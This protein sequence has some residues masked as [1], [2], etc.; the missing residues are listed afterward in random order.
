MKAGDQAKGYKIFKDL[1]GKGNTRAENEMGVMNEHGEGIP[2][3]SSEAMKWYLKAADKGYPLAQCNIGLMFYKGEGVPR[4][5]VQAYKWFDLA[6]L[7]GN[8]HA[9]GYIDIIVR[10][11]NHGE[12]VEGQRLAR[13]WQSKSA[14]P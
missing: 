6:M 1:A 13:E 5:L 12:I 3:D 10:E 9:R 4:D 8:P 14:K 7:K 2:R 11:M